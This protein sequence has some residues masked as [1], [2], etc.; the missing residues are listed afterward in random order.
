[1]RSHI[2]LLLLL[3]L[4]RTLLPEAWILALHA[5][6]HTTVEPAHA[7]AAA[8]KGKSLVSAE[9]KHCQVEHFYNASFQAAVPVRVPM[10]RVWPGY[11]AQEAPLAVRPPAGLLA[12]A[13][14]LR[15]PP[16]RA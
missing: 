3:C 15:G 6:A 14:A 13:C 4:T 16:S 1:M 5:H 7:P 8:H 2:A 11:A 9:H 12:R 10:P